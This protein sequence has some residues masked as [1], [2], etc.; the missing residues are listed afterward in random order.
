MNKL[1]LVPPDSLTRTLTNDWMLGVFSDSTGNKHLFVISTTDY[2]QDAFSGMLQWEKVMADDLRL[3][4][5]SPAIKGIANAP[6]QTVPNNLISATTSIVTASTTTK[7]ANAT[8][9][10]TSTTSSKTKKPGPK[11][12]I[13]ATS[14]SNIATTTIAIEPAFTNSSLTLDGQFQDRIIMNK[15]VRAFVTSH[16]Q[17]LFLYSFIDNEHL[18]FAGDESAISEILTRLEKQTFIR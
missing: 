3:Y 7:P 9:S 13:A 18:V 11:A 14:T 2:F 17:T 1:S 12:N 15:D 5:T 8:S 16:G 10:K 6:G 4:I